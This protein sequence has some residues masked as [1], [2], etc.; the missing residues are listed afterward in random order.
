MICFFFG[1]YFHSLY[2]FLLWEEP[3]LVVAYWGAKIQGVGFVRISILLALQVRA[4]GGMVI[5]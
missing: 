3:S 1:F 2:F 5:R 4:F